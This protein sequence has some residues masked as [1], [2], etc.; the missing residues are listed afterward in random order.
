MTNG[1]PTTAT[2]LSALVDGALVYE[3][4]VEI[5]DQLV[6]LLPMGHEPSMS[7]LIVEAVRDALAGEIRFVFPS[8]SE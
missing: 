8:A 6:H 7:P 1:E 2:Q 4:W 5:V 3:Q